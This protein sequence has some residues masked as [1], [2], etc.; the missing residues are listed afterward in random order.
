M[1]FCDADMIWVGDV[2]AKDIMTTGILACDHPWLHDQPRR[3]F[4]Y[5]RRWQSCAF[6]PDNKGVKYYAGAIFG[7]ATLPLIEHAK[8][9][10][11]G[12]AHDDLNGITAVWHD[13]SHHNKLLAVNK[14][15]KILPVSF[16]YDPKNG[17]P[18]D[19]KIM[20]DNDDSLKVR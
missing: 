20:C 18:E 12:V 8:R 9:I 14:P 19:P 10:K 3:R 4:T 16:C 5:E 1:L 7:G 11:S 2:Y 13:E 6:V 17:T 15:T